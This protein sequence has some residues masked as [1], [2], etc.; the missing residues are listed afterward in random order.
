ME[1]R[2]V[3]VVDDEKNIRFT[4]E[5]SLKTQGLEIQTAV[6]G[7][8]ALQKLKEKRYDIVLLD[9]KMPGIDGLEV[10]QLI[11]DHWPKTRVAIISAH[12]TID[13]AVQAMKLGAVDFIQKPFSPG[14]IR[15]LVSQVLDREK[16]DEEDA[17]DYGS[18]IELTKRFISDRCFKKAIITVR[19]AIGIDPSQPEAYNMYGALL[20][21]TDDW[22]EALK[23]YRAALDINPT[24]KPARMNLDRVTSWN[25]FGRIDMGP[26]KEQAK[27]A[28]KTE[29][30]ENGA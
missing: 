29:R 10:L 2:S 8:D 18:L 6:N 21:M 19:K 23:F 9:L 12:G 30:E 4:V 7:E 27:P 1:Q 13:T 17:V 26:N 3:L 11:S 24:Y 28:E 20:E 5:A 16:L 14:E 25:K 22:L 15:T